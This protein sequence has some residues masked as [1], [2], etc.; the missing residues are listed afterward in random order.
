M[1]FKF[2]VLFLLFTSL[3]VFSQRDF[4][5][6]Q[7][8]KNGEYEKALNE[9]KKLHAKSSSNFNYIKQVIASYQQL[10]QF[11]EAESFIQ[12][13]L[14]RQS[15]P[16]LYV[17]LGY[18]F[19]LNNN[20]EKANE[21]Y[22]IA[23]NS[24]LE[25]ANYSIAIARAFQDHVLLE[26]AA[27]TYEKAMEIRPELN[28]KLQ[29]AKIYGEQGLIE[30]ML[31]NYVDFIAEKP[32]A[33]SNVKRAIDDFISEDG[34][35]ENNSL[36]KKILI[37]KIQL[38]PNIIWNEM[39][40]WLFIQQKDFN[41]AFVQEKAIYKREIKGLNRIIEL[42]KIAIAEKEHEL[43]KEIF[44]YVI[45]ESQDLGDKLQANYDLLQLQI[46]EADDKSYTAIENKFLEL[47]DTYGKFTQTLDL[48]ILYA[49]FLAFHKNKTKEATTFL[50][51][52]LEL[53]LSTIK[54]AEVKLELG[55]IL[56]LQEKF[57]K[58]LIYYTQIQR[59]LKNST[60]S[61]KARF[62][63]AKTSYYK[64]DFKWAESQLKILKSSTSQL[65]A[66]DALDLKLLISDNKYEDSL[67]TALTLYAKAD[68]LAFQ[69]RNEEA[70]DVLN[71]VLKNHKTEPIIPQALYKQGQLFELKK[72]FEKAEAN[73]QHVIENYRNGILVD[74]AIYSLA[75]LYLN[76]LDQPEKAKSLYKDIV[77][78]F[79]DSIYYIEARKK[80][81]RLRGDAIN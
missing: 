66:N 26:Q 5:A 48:Q 32:N 40:S 75:E 41:K 25:N 16:G 53:P 3:S 58:A 73:Y 70:I 77:F 27:A 8:Y 31:L 19:Q 24:L 69:N 18:N 4:V 74:N 63:V 81:R 65:I 79:A 30:K 62:K 12:Q 33:L 64:G 7:Y 13:V 60:I 45:D 67:Q 71:T 9:Y 37:K 29:L 38:D 6:K 34:K 50:E 20:L 39:L 17:E 44:Q 1:R 61:Q 11:K 55:D 72:Q 59:N 76:Q 43:A 21:N 22:N 56:V 36:L 10:Q 46:V 14:L 51:T 28:F 78:N 2:I 42:G 23:I 57:N 54:K 80:Y 47:F 15:Y 68:L 49:H 52:A 35:H